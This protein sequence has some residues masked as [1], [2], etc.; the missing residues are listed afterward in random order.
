[1]A[2]SNRLAQVPW[3]LAEY[4]KDDVAV[5]RRNENYWGERPDLEQVIVR[6]IPDGETRVIAFESGEL[7]LIYGNGVISLDAF[8]QLQQ[9]G[10]FQAEIS[11]PLSTRAIAIHSGRGPTQEL[12]VRRAIQHS[13]NKDAVIE[14]IFYNTE[15]RADTYFSDEVPYANIGLE[16]YNY[17]VEQANAL[18]EEAGWTLPAGG[19]I[20]QK[21]GQPLVL[22]LSFNALNNIDKAIAEALQADLRRVGIDLRLLGEEQQSWLERQSNGEFHL[23]FNDTWVPPY[24]PHAMVSSMRK[25]SHADYEAQSGLPM[26]A[27]IDRKIALVLISTDETT[28]QQLYRDL[29]TT[30]HE[31]AVYLPISYSTNLAVFRETINGFEFAS[32]YQSNSV[33]AVNQDP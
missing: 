29:L 26:K 16:P 8:Q 23:I 12:A 30:L 18:L 19:A 4:R 1:M 2:S 32:Q 13:F 3:V 28:R 22:E 9:S 10:R 7:D 11:Q 15:R 5:F 31:Q 25:P 20:R 17:N 21:N 33:Q 14:A 27:E 6:I 24:E